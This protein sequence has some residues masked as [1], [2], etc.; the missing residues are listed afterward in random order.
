MM[1][2]ETIQQMSDEAGRLAA[3]RN[4]QPYVPY[5]EDDVERMPGGEKWNGRRGFP[6]PDLGS[7]QPEGWTDT[8]ESY[9]VDS[10]GFG[11]DDEPALTWQQFNRQIIA[12]IV[13]SPRRL[14]LGITQVGQ[15]Q[16]YVSIF[17]KDE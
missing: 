15:F 2:L 10:S 14:G 3:Q 13:R 16:L 9:F 8:G 1:S 6:F 11:R 17:E 12:D 5:N 4:L 7:H